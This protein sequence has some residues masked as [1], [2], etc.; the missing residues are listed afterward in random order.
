MKNY[1]EIEAAFLQA[2]SYAKLLMSSVIVLCD[3]EC[4]LVYENKEGFSRSRYKKYYWEDMKIPDLY[5][6]LKKKLVFNL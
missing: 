1:Q 4:I 3:K 5:N 6:E 2:F